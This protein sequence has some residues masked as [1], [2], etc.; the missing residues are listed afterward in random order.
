MLAAVPGSP[1]LAERAL[2]QAVAA[3]DRALAV[4]AAGSLAPHPGA[5]PDARMLLFAEALRVRDWRAAEAHVDALSREPVFG[6]LAPILRAWAAQDR[7][8]DPQPLLAPGVVDPGVAP[9]IDE[10]RVLLLLARGDDGAAAALAQAVDGAGPRGERLRLLGATALQQ[11]GKSGAAE[12]L[13]AGDSRALT[14]GRQAL[15]AGRLDE[16]V[17]DSQSG[18]AELLARLG[19]D[20]AAQGGT[21]TALGFARLAMLLAPGHAPARLLAAEL[22]AARGAT[23][24]ATAL[25]DD[26]LVPGHYRD[27]LEESRIFI[28]A[29]ADREAE[30]IA[31]ARRAV[32]NSADATTLG[33]LGDVLMG[34]RRYGEAAD[35]YARALALPTSPGAPQEWLLTLLRGMAL[36]QSGRWRD[37]KPVLERAHALAPGE[38]IV[39]NYLG[40]AQIEKRENIVAA[41]ALIEQAARLRPDDAAITDSLGWSYFLRGRTAEAIPLLEKAAAGEA[42]DPAIHEHLGDAYYTAGRRIEARFAWDRALRGIRPDG[43]ARVQAKIDR[44]LSPE[45]A[46]P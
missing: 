27:A 20:A 2:R 11:Q 26:E 14:L 17:I 34:A 22:L 9:Y 37:A 21:E 4:R 15:A 19:A 31:V 1:G 10:H 6:L 8:R 43:A 25:L 45:L 3:G 33:R 46:A 36:D 40:Y 7:G 41:Q 32:A 39:L 30:A 12:L 18:I 24:A 29:E 13:L 42:E 5:V 28:L 16:R 23:D 44:G 38:A 35:V